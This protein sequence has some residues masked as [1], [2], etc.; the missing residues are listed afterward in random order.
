MFGP[1]PFPAQKKFPV[2]CRFVTTIYLTWLLDGFRV[3]NR[4]KR[5]G[6][7]VLYEKIYR[8]VAVDKI[9]I[10]IRRTWASTVQVYCTH[11]HAYEDET[12][13]GARPAVYNIVYAA[14]KRRKSITTD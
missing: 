12:D 3:A 7:T 1:V 5:L 8:T 4:S 14:Y 11:A 13:G 10:I 2:T 6:G 9:I